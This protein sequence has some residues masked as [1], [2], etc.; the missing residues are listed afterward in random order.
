M[1]KINFDNNRTYGTNNNEG[2][3]FYQQ[4][5]SGTWVQIKG[6]SDTPIFKSAKQFALYVKE[7]HA[8]ILEGAEVISS[9][10]WEK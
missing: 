9:F 3:L 4:S 5:Q 8:G 6:N 10:G 2:G 1:R 7:I